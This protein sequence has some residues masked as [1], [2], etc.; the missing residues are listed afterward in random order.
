MKTLPLFHQ[1]AGRRC[2]VVGGGQVAWRKISLLLDADANVHA[3]A[4]AA[5]PAVVDAADA[6]RLEL[7]LRAFDDSDVDGVALVIAA[8]ND[9]ATNATISHAAM[10]ANVPVN[11]VDQPQDSSVLFPAIVDRDD[12][13][14][15]VSTGGGSPTLARLVRARLE[16]LL[17]RGL[18]RLAA[19]A[20]AHRQRVKAAVG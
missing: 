15:A 1:L 19:F 2:L 20:R 14:V 12:V 18:G 3:V 17:P 8:T 11:C 4:L 7:S 5:T 10:N 9:R 13:V 16:S 6:G